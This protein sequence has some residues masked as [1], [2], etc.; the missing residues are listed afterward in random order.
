M[1]TINNIEL[2]DEN[3][4]PDEKVLEEI[5]GPSFEAYQNLLKLFDENNLEYTWR[6]YKDGKAWLCKVQKKRRTIVWMS[7]W[8][9]YMQAIIYIPGKYV[10]DIYS[11]D[12]SEGI[13]AKIKQTKNVGKSM[14]CIFEV[15][16]NDVFEDFNK[17]MQF[18]I[19]AK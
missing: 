19:K 17:V 7:A 2:R 8:K 12:I 13:K 16:D 6:Y 3:V 1:E 15:R 9:G 14:P 11:L 4:Y 5:L 18:K 10:E